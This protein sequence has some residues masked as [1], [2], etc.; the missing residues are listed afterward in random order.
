MMTSIVLCEKI[1]KSLENV[2]LKVRKQTKCINYKNTKQLSLGIHRG[3]VPGA[4]PP[5][6]KIHRHSSPLY[7][8]VWYLHVTYVHLL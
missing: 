8:M 5:D 2:V 7:R 3:C 1:D 4:P 6:T